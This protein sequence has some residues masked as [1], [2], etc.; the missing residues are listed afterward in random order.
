MKKTGI[1]VLVLVCLLM[2]SGCSCGVESCLNR[3]PGAGDAVDKIQDNLDQVTPS[4]GQFTIEVVNATDDYNVC[5]CFISDSDLE[6][7]GDD[8]FGDTILYPGDSFTI[9]VDQGSYDI[10]L[11]DCNDYVLHTAWGVSGSTRIEIGGPGKIPLAVLNQSEY[12]VAYMY[13]SLSSADDWGPDWL[14]DIEVIP[15][16]DGARVFFVNPGT[17]DFKA[18][19]IDNE[20]IAVQEAVNLTESSTW[21]IYN[22]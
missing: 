12:E 5:Y 21:T 13:I 3:I 2:L 8:C 19:D 16:Y 22:E 18:D 1:L 17:Y 7:W 10:M 4:G 20:T 11:G 9:T 14:A 6:D 15:P